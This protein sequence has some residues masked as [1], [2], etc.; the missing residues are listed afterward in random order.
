MGIPFYYEED[1]TEYETQKYVDTIKI[2]EL[3]DN[4]FV[5]SDNID[6]YKS[7]YYSQSNGFIALI[8]KMGDGIIFD[9]LDIQ[10]ITVQHDNSKNVVCIYKLNDKKT[11]EVNYKLK[12][13][14]D[15]LKILDISIM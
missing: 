9:S 7:K 8:S 15:K 11:F 4:I 2:K 10:S 14:D 1:N 3:I 5:N 13:V 12:M 6:L